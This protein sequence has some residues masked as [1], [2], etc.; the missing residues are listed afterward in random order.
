MKKNSEAKRRIVEVTSKLFYEN[1][2]P[3][4]GTNE[5]LEKSSTFKNTLYK[6]F[7][8]KTD[9][10]IYYIQEVEEEIVNLIKRMLD[11]YPKFEDF[12]KVWIQL[13]QRKESIK[14][15]LGCPLANI[16]FQT[17]KTPAIQE[18]VQVGFKRIK[19]VFA[20]YF[21]INYTCTEK[22]A[23]KLSEEVLFL[24]EG[25]MT[26]YGME[27]NKKYFDYLQLHFE[28]ISKRILQK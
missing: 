20:D 9:L 17:H 6:Y 7:P 14:Y 10:G 13:I 11:K 5:I 4:T 25:A 28:F 23:I 12:S 3:Q 24:Y 16:Y 21:L 22:E 2:Y 19:S 15:F 1:G 18:R 26:M 27:Q 8:S